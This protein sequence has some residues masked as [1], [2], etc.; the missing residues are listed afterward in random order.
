[1]KVHYMSNTNEWYTPFDLFNTL[2]KRFDF[3]LDP[4]ATKENAKCENYFNK[5]D[6]G[7]SQNWYGSVFV[8]PPYGRAIGKWV[9]KAY[10]ESLKECVNNVVMLIPA[11]TDTI[12]WHDW[13][14]PFAK[15]IMFIKGRLKFGGSKNSAPFPSAIIIFNNNKDRVVS[16]SDKTGK[17][18]IENITKEKGN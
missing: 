2:D 5:E 6:D 8:N 7:L 18:I 1:M 17:Y 9:E 13:I 4:C 3:N 10:K 16:T 11:R 12:Y 14:F 15:E